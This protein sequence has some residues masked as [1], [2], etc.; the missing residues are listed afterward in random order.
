[1]SRHGGERGSRRAWGRNYLVKRPSTVAARHTRESSAPQFGAPVG[2]ERAEWPNRRFPCEPG[3]VAII[4]GLDA[5]LNEPES[6]CA[7]L[8]SRLLPRGAAVEAEFARAFPGR[9]IA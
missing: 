5:D 1:V 7:P 8:R 3:R 6:A 2:R 9:V 4:A